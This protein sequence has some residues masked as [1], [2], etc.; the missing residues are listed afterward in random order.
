MKEKGDSEGGKGERGGEVQKPA[1]MVP[2]QRERGKE[3]GTGK[4]QE[5]GGEIGGV[6]GLRIGL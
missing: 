3:E 2:V 1:V 4:K 5:K 6:L